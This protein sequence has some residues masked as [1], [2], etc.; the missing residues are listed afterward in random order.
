[1][2]MIFIDSQIEHLK[3]IIGERISM[4]FDVNGELYIHTLRTEKN[5]K[6]S[7]NV[8]INNLGRYIII[9]DN[10]NLFIIKDL[11]GEEL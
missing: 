4:N 10:N 9:S 11:E 2:L 8:K 5:I 7:S 6:L 3:E 1:M